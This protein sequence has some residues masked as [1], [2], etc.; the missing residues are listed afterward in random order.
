MYENKI[1][2]FAHF[3]K[4]KNKQK[5]GATTVNAIQVALLV[6][7]LKKARHAGDK[8]NYH[9]AQNMHNTMNSLP[10]L[11]SIR[12]RATGT[13]NFPGDFMTCAAYTCAAMFGTQKLTSFTSSTP[14]PLLTEKNNETSLEHNHPCKQFIV[15]IASKKQ[16]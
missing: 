2:M 1:S 7:Q 3:R 14:F 16:S 13:Q 9:Y 6:G 12:Q 11:S 4:N 8:P 10:H 15:V 5:E